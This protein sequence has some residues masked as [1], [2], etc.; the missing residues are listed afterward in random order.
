MADLFKIAI[1]GSLKRGMVKIVEI[2]VA[3]GDV[4]QNG[5]GR[6]D[7]SQG[8]LDLSFTAGLSNASFYFQDGVYL[9]ILVTN[10]YAFSNFFSKVFH[11]GIELFKDV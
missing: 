7:E 2:F 3:H 9:L 10:T 6:L 5:F 4:R 8:R 1:I 11:A